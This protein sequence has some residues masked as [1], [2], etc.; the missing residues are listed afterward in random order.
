MRAYVEETSRLNRERRSNG[1]A[2]KV[3]L[4]K[5][6]KQIVEA[7]VDGMYHPSMKEKM[8]GLEARKEALT[9]LLANAPW[10]RRIFCR[11]RRPSTRTRLQP[12]R[13]A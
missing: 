13:K 7:I 8:T 2:W 6:E 5:V 3:G 10:T 4:P 9:T 12:W 1:D 11:V